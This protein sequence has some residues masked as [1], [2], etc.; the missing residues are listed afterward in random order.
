MMTPAQHYEAADAQLVVLQDG[1]AQLLEI[2]PQVARRDVD[3]Y[4]A[5]NSRLVELHIRMA[6]V[7]ISNLP[8]VVRQKVRRDAEE[9]D[10]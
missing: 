10:R 5:V 4:M 6:M 1:L 2:R 3:T 7:P 8:E 9:A